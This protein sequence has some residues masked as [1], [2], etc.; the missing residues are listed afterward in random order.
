VELV[1]K[2]AEGPR[3]KRGQS[4]RTAADLR[5]EVH[6][7]CW[8]EL[9]V[10]FGEGPWR[11]SIPGLSRFLKDPSEAEQQ[12]HELFVRARSAMI[13]VVVFAKLEDDALRNGNP[14][15]PGPGRTVAGLG[16]MLRPL[17]DDRSMSIP[18]GLSA[19]LKQDTIDRNALLSES[20]RAKATPPLPRLARLGKRSRLI[21]MLDNYNSLSLPP[22]GN[23]WH[24]SSRFLTAREF[25][26]V[27]LV[28]NAG[29][30]DEPSAAGPLQRKGATPAEVIHEE[31]KRMRLGLKRHGYDRNPLYPWRGRDPDNPLKRGPA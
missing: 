3:A 24:N 19:L 18:T 16:R 21:F 11:Q 2:K 20:K 1:E 4:K 8:N 17:L 27:S 26:L 22:H 15:T 25:A 7:A 9:T 13:D 30:L 23:E 14:T 29:V 28:L 10:A 5:T 31:E 12:A 6:A